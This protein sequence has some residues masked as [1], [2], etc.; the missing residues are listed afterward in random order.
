MFHLNGNM[1][2]EIS[3]QL[4]HIKIAQKAMFNKQ[5]TDVKNDIMTFIVLSESNR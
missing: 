1:H 4:E 5:F 2:T 3:S